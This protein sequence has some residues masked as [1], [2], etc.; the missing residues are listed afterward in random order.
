MAITIAG[1]LLEP[2]LQRHFT[3]YRYGEINCVVPPSKGAQHNNTPPLKCATRNVVRR[4]V[5]I[6]PLLSV[7]LTFY[8]LHAFIHMQKPE[9]FWQQNIAKKWVKPLLGE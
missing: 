3:I 4:K 2:F 9:E 1:K 7:F 8:F 5:K 6:P